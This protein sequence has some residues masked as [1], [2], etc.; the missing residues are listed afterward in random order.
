MNKIDHHGN[1]VKMTKE[2][3]KTKKA[4]DE[5]LNKI[6]FPTKTKTKE[7]KITNEMTQQPVSSINEIW[8]ITGTRKKVDIIE[9]A[10]HLLDKAYGIQVAEITSIQ[11]QFKHGERWNSHVWFKQ[12]IACPDCGDKILK[13]SSEYCYNEYCPSKQRME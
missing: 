3:I 2:E 10:K 9:A 12:T 7:N 4:Q 11:G 5:I 13:P 6:L 1:K 8:V